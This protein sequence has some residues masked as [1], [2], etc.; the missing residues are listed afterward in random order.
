MLFGLLLHSTITIPSKLF[1]SCNIFTPNITL[2]MFGRL[3]NIILRPFINTEKNS[4]IIYIYLFSYLKQAGIWIIITPWVRTVLPCMYV[5]ILWYAFRNGIKKK[6]SWLRWSPDNF[7]LNVCYN[8]IRIMVFFRFLDAPFLSYSLILTL[9]LLII[10]QILTCWHSTCWHN[11][12][13]FN[14]CIQSTQRTTRW[15]Q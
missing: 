15:F 14:K 13:Y 7:F 11:F 8:L 9:S 6:Y 12:F 10:A 3:Y 1:F 5:P 4:Y 2:A